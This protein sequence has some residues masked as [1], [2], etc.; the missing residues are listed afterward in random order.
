[1]KGRIADIRLQNSETE[2]TKATFTE[3][4][5]LSRSISVNIAK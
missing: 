1:L 2:G 5:E 3:L 4:M